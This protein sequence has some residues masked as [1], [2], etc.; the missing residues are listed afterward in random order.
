LENRRSDRNPEGQRVI[1]IEAQ[2]GVNGSEEL[3]W[4][5]QQYL[6][7]RPL[8]IKF[9]EVLVSSQVRQHIFDDGELIFVWFKMLV[10]R[11]LII[12]AYS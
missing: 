5:V 10:K 9:A 3:T 6:V 7:E 1:F 2:W 4:R 11:H 8:K 12:S